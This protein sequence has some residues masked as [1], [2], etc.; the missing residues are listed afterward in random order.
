MSNPCWIA[1]NEIREIPT[2]ATSDFKNFDALAPKML[3]KVFTG[4]IPSSND[5][6]LNNLYYITGI[7]IIPHLCLSIE[8]PGNVGVLILV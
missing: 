3:D 7:D 4:D 1:R 2:R 5:L 8:A 6:P